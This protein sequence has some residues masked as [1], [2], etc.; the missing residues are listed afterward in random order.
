M[1]RVPAEFRWLFWEVDFPALD[2]TRDAD[3]ILTRILEF[4]RM[5][6]VRWAIQTYGMPRIHVYFQTAPHPELSEQTLSFWRS[7]LNAQEESWPLPPDW[8]KSSTA[9]W[10]S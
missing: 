2:A 8:R 7:A 9:P 4:G 1:D 6:E 3:F 10:V 5:E